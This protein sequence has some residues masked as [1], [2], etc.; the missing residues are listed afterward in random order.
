MCEAVA[1]THASLLYG[2]ELKGQ[3][4]QDNSTLVQ[5]VESIKEELSK[6]TQLFQGFSIEQ[7]KLLDEL[8]TLSIKL[9]HLEGFHK[10]TLLTLKASLEE[11]IKIVEAHTNQH[12]KLSELLY[13]L[14]TFLK[15]S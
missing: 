2:K 13:A 3:V 5:L 6:V 10:D 12:L 8:Q 15:R 11:G 9:C 4:I 1:K 14:E 7:R